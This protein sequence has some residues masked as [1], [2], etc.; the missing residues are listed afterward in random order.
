MHGA[1]E[2]PAIR[3]GYLAPLKYSLVYG[4]FAPRTSV[5]CCRYVIR[6]SPLPGNAQL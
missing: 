3:T 6:D 4:F 2:M 5:N 1:N